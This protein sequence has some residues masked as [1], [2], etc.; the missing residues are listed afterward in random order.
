MQNQIVTLFLAHP[1]T[2]VQIEIPL[3]EDISVDNPDTV[4]RY[5]ANWIFD[6]VEAE[7]LGYEIENDNKPVSTYIATGVDS[8]SNEFKI[9]CDDPIDIDDIFEIKS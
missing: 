1:I 2:T 6:N 3:P 4:N 5:V 8:D 7:G 9:F